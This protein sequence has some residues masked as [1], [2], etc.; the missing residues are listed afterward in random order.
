MQQYCYSCKQ[1]REI[2]IVRKKETYSVKGEPITIMANVCTCNVCG[3]ELLSIQYD[4]D[5]LR[6]AYSVYRTRHNLLQ[7]EEIAAIRERYGLSQQQFSRMLGLD[8]KDIKR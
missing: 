8:E 1:N 5:N 2:R 7:P 6:R 3:T 4:D